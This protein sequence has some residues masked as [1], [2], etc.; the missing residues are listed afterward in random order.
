MKTNINSIMISNDDVR[1]EIRKVIAANL[2]SFSA[3]DYH[4]A[5]AAANGAFGNASCS[6]GNGMFHTASSVV[7]KFYAF[8]DI[9]TGELQLFKNIE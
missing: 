8:A 2:K 9:S 6:A 5:N 7:G 3:S 1:T 4:D